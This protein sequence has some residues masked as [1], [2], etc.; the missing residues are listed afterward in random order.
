M[1]T[2][3]E[4][5]LGSLLGSLIVKLL[6]ENI[7]IERLG[8]TKVLYIC[9]SFWLFAY[10]SLDLAQAGTKITFVTS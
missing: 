1:W 10:E 8:L 7:F 4:R 5:S 3:I 9:V 6:L 2:V